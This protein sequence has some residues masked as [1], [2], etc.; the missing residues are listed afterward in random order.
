MIFEK[1]FHTN[2]TKS[3]NIFFDKY[4]SWEIQKDCNII[5]KLEIIFQFKKH[6]KKNT[7]M[8]VSQRQTSG[9]S[10]QSFHLTT[11]LIE[12]ERPIQRG[13]PNQIYSQQDF[14]RCKWQKYP[15]IPNIFPLSH[16]SKNIDNKNW[17]KNY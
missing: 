9:G 14:T 13:T 7:E 3:S 5:G 6:R 16:G 2:I 15:R 12:K 11:S 1:S 4:L 8:I 17:K 10:I